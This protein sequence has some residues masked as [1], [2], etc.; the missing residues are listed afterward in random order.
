MMGI[1][2]KYSDK[3]LLI[4]KPDVAYNLSSIMLN[5]LSARIFAPFTFS[6]KFGNEAS[7]F[8]YHSLSFGCFV[9][10]YPSA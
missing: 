10:S 2:S 6:S 5:I 4:D 8:W 9:K 1:K 7:S 3:N